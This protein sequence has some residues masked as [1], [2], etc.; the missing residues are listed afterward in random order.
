VTDWRNEAIA[1]Y[2]CACDAQQ[3]FVSLPTLHGSGALI[4]AVLCFRPVFSGG[5]PLRSYAF[6]FGHAARP[7]AYFTSFT[8]QIVS[9]VP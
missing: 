7:P 9:S 4:P 1:P 6:L 3:T 2:K 8:P 5:T